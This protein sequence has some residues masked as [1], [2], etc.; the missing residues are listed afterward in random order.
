MIHCESLK[1]E[2]PN[3][4][5]SNLTLL[6]FIL[7][8]FLT[9]YSCGLGQATEDA[10][11]T[12]Q[13]FHHHMREHHHTAIL[14]MIDEEALQLTSKEEWMLL[15]STIDQ[16]FG[17]MKKVSQ[18]LSFNTSINNDVTIVDLNYTIEFEERT[19]SE[20]ITLRKQGNQE[21]KILN[22]IIE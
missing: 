15:F 5:K 4:M 16:D 13:V 9:L 12:A 21:F 3:I 19:V 2:K 7:T 11:K 6:G 14:K 20:K 22:F 1:M 10:E 8:S 17:Q 18:Y